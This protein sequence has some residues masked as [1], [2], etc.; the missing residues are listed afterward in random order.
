MTRFDKLA[1]VISAALLAITLAVIGAGLAGVYGHP[2]ER[3]CRIEVYAD[4]SAE[5]LCDAGWQPTRPIS[6]WPIVRVEA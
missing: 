1:L 2:H 3:H 4:G 5:P 6:E